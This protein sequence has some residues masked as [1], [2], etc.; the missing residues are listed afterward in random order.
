MCKTTPPHEK[1]E[2]HTI[3]TFSRNSKIKKT[4]WR[5]FK[6]KYIQGERMGKLVITSSVVPF[7]K[8]HLRGDIVG[9]NLGHTSGKC[10]VK[11]K[12]NQK[13]L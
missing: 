11:N 12:K 7:A 5:N 1:F 6:I 2:I 4:Q 9:V 8:L 10:N 13:E 3:T